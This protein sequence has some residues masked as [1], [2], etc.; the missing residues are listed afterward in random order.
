MY[1]SFTLFCFTNISIVNMF[2]CQLKKEKKEL[3]NS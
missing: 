3:A 1:L 2:M